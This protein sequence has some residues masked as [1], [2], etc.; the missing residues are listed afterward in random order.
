MADPAVIPATLPFPVAQ[1]VG[2]KSSSFK[3]TV[4]V[5]TV[6]VL[7]MG[8]SAIFEQL[9]Q[10]YPATAW[11]GMIS[12]ALA[13]IAPVI[14]YITGRQKVKVAELLVAGAHAIAQ[15]YGP[16]AGWNALG[17]GAPAAPQ[18]TAPVPPNP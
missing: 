12:G 14:A 11:I 5:S 15:T 4:V 8:L 2:A 6:G 9:V 1:D 16:Q 10:L 3:L 7:V 17:V 13:A 18:L